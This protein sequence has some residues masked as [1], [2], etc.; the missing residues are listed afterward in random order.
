MAKFI[1][2]Q[3]DRCKIR[4]ETDNPLPDGWLVL[5]SSNTE[6][7]LCADCKH[8]FEQFMGE[9]EKAARPE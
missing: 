4:H 5:W 1:M 2:C 8:A 3:C 7:Y 6:M 9:I